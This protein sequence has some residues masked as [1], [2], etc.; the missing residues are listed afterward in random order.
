V[1]ALTLI[2]ANESLPYIIQQMFFHYLPYSHEDE[3]LS[4]EEEEEEE[5]DNS[6]QTSVFSAFSAL[7]FGNE[8][9]VCSDGLL[10]NYEWPVDMEEVEVKNCDSSF[11]QFPTQSTLTQ[12]TS[13]TNGRKRKLSRKMA[14]AL[15]S[16]AEKKQTTNQPPKKRQRSELPQGVYE[17]PN[18][19]WQ[20]RV[21]Y[22]GSNRNIGTFPI[23]EQATLANETARNM[24]KKDRGLQLSTEEYEQNFKQAKEAAWAVKD[25]TKRPCGRPR[26]S[27]IPAGMTE[28][29]NGN[30]QVRVFFQGSYRC[31]GTFPTFEQATLADEIARSMFKKSTSSVPLNE[32][33]IEA[34][35]RTA[36]K[37]VSEMNME[38][39]KDYFI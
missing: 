35:K 39:E 20:V 16:E 9:R 3:S 19:T 25:T 1:S 18:S 32:Q 34:I 29:G 13:L 28:R 2:G 31:I 14:D 4:Y 24:L 36:L 22:Q 38:K 11:D 7:S 26:K 37:G 27:S 23:L 10:A 5:E 21:F 6:D 17:T 12:S 8:S 33:E 15:D 30:W